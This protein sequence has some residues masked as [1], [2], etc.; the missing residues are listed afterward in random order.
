MDTNRIN[1]IN[2]DLSQGV[3][4]SVDTLKGFTVVKAEKGPIEPVFIPANS[5]ATIHEVLG[6]PS[7]T[8]PDIQE[9]IDFNN[10]YGVFV[11]APY[12]EDA[13]NKVPVAYVTPAGIFASA[14][15]VTITG[16]R[17]ED[18]AMDEAAIEGIN[19]LS[20][21]PA[22]LI[23]VGKEQ[24]YFG[25]AEADVAAPLGYEVGVTASSLTINFA[26]SIALAALNTTKLAAHFLD[27]TALSDS[28]MAVGRV[29]KNPRSDTGS[30]VAVL[31]FDIPGEAALLELHLKIVDTDYEITDSEGNLICTVDGASTTSISINSEDVREALV[32][33]AAEYFSAN[34]ITSL[35]SDE[36]FRNSVRVYW[37]AELYDA[38]VFATI[39]PKYLSER[40]TTL[41]FG[42]QALGNRI[43]MTVTEL[44]TPTSYSTKTLTGSLL[45]QDVDGFGAS[46]HFADRLASQNL[47]AVAVIKPFANTVFTATGTIAAPRFTLEPVVL[48]R[49]ARIVPESLEAG[50][51]L[52]S[53]PEYDVV[54]VF[55]NTHAITA[56]QETTFKTLAATHKL[57]R[58]VAAQH[59]EPTAAVEEL[60]A[61]N[62][63]HNY[64][65][66]TNS[67]V[68]RSSYT[69][70]DFI[71]SAIGAYAAMILR[72]VELKMGGAAPMFLNSG[73]VGGQLALSV[74]K[75]TY[76]YSK[77]Q[78]TYLDNAGYNPIILD[79]TYGVMV[80]GQKTAKGGELSDWSYVGHMSAFLR[81]QREVRDT[82][83]TP[84]IG[85]PNNPYY[86][87]LRKQ[88]VDSL[89]RPR[90]EGMGRI[91]AAAVCDTA[92][93]TV[94]TR[95]IQ[96]QRKFV[97]K[98]TLRVDIF[99]EAVDLVMVN[100]DQYTEI[101]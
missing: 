8:Y 47:I 4:S 29:V 57:A 79:S 55:F 51:Q 45:E 49:G 93:A 96:A 15:P 78:L 100:V 50:W 30:T 27:Q 63:G 33:K 86:R 61:L 95:D 92:E 40:T 82:V 72:A 1:I 7:A 41:T 71:S 44:V 75:A 38:A 37:K 14:A 53:S 58:Y 10:Q 26:F 36:T 31:V 25:T 80:V 9:V 70:E 68:R 52:A 34:A 21:N 24:S 97:V 32:G 54:E 98:V 94:N 101:Q 28:T 59:V 84:Q 35:W 16:S 77:D 39:Y 17:L 90:I 11:S 62:Y 2:Q 18:V 5:L 22:V 66:S 73:G 81:F 85:K 3:A 83:L 64:I 76:K 23:P 69:R 89:L 43:S 74:K 67:F 56:E 65:I 99:S 48:S 42:K 91:W 60:A 13:A 88:Q 19:L 46:L 20:S 87:D 6:Y 12:D